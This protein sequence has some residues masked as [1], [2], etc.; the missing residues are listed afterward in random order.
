MN[1]SERMYFS[2][3]YRHVEALYNYNRSMYRDTHNLIYFYL[4]DVYSSQLVL[5]RQM[6]DDLGLD[7][8][9]RV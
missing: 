9:A 1:Y 3:K 7:R 8:K 4:A 6:I 5:L 2:I